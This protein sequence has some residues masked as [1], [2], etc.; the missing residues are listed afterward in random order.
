LPKAK[1]KASGTGITFNISNDASG[2]KSRLFYVRVSFS[3]VKNRIFI[4]AQNTKKYGVIHQ[5]M[6]ITCE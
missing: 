6:W 2:S 1:A 5:T 3:E 4:R